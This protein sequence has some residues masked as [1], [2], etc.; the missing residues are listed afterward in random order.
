M[1]LSGRQCPGPEKYG[2]AH[3]RYIIIKEPPSNESDIQ[4]NV[5]VCGRMTS[6][7]PVDSP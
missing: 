6:H 4:K 2:P 5:V 3:A 7:L 1:V